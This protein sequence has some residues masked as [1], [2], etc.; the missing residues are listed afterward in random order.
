MV[1]YRVQKNVMMAIRQMMMDVIDFVILNLYV[2]MELRKKVRNAM[3]EILC[4]VMVALIVRLKVKQSAIME[5]V[6]LLRVFVVMEY[7]NFNLEKPV[8]MAILS[9]EMGVLQLAKLKQT[10]S[11]GTN[12]SHLS[13]RYVEMV[14]LTLERLVMILTLPMEMDVV[15]LVKSRIILSVHPSLLHVHL[16]LFQ[17][18]VEMV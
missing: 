8:M 5:Y 11:V 4:P 2:E 10:T 1:F 17:L 3:M 9:M 7:R 15:T 6:T 12:S 18:F 16:S 14:C 13:V